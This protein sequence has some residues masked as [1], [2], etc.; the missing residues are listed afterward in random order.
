MDSGFG[1]GLFSGGHGSRVEFHSWEGLANG[2]E[3]TLIWE[4]AALY[5]IAVVQGLIQP[6]DP[7]WWP[8]EE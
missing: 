6:P 3:G 2:Y 8:E 5:G 1:D 7:E 4:F